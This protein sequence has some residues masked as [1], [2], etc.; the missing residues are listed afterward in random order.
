MAF[1][2][3]DKRLAG[4]AHLLTRSASDAVR[5]GVAEIARKWLAENPGLRDWMRTFKDRDCLLH[6]GN[7]S[8]NP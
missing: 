5:P 3:T 8:R 4:T 1:G 6:L 2:T 7:R